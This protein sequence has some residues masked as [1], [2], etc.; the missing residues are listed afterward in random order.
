M[1][2]PI[3]RP[4]S[5]CQSR[6]T[7]WSSL[8][9]LI[10]YVY[11]WYSLNTKPKHNKTFNGYKNTHE[12]ILDTYLVLLETTPVISCHIGCQ[13]SHIGDKTNHI[14]HKSIPLPLWYDWFWLD[15][16]LI[17]VDW[18]VYS[19]I[20]LKYSFILKENQ[21]RTYKYIYI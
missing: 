2:A 5:Q 13:L 14:G 11:F 18:L 1:Y 15:F 20:A 21:R 9:I 3:C 16:C 4:L 8:T 12:A 7:L 19:W 17:W 10:N 6:Q